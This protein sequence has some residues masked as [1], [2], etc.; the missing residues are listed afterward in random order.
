MADIHSIAYV[1]RNV[2]GERREMTVHNEPLWPWIV[3]IVLSLAF[4]LGVCAVG[5]ATGWPW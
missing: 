4:V 1:P 3:V 2:N 5:G